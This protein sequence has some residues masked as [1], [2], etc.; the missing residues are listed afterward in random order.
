MNQIV[1]VENTYDW[2]PKQTLMQPKPEG[3][4]LW[5]KINTIGK[6][7]SFGQTYMATDCEA[8]GQERR[9]GTWFD[10]VRFSNNWP[11]SVLWVAI[12]GFST[13][14]H[15]PIICQFEI[16]Q[17]AGKLGLAPSHRHW[18]RQRQAPNGNAGAA[19]QQERGLVQ[20]V[21]NLKLFWNFEYK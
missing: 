12:C 17:C 2:D 3:R 20:H 15:P 7:A 11:C 5:A 9:S 21:L 13:P 16:W 4:S 19:A 10:C 8:P 1:L 6:Y 18:P 14:K